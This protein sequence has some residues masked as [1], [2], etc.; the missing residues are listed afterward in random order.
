MRPPLPVHVYARMCAC[1][2]LAGYNCG[3]ELERVCVQVQVHSCARKR[4]AVSVGQMHV[5]DPGCRVHV[6]VNRR[7]HWVLLGLHFVGLICRGVGWWF[8]C[9]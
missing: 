8:L 7:V 1:Q 2:C 9:T 3:Y 4:P 6:L 5:P